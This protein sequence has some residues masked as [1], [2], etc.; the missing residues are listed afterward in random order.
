MNRENSATEVPG[1]SDLAWRLPITKGWM[2]SG[3]S[4]TNEGIIYVAHPEGGSILALEVGGESR[5]IPTGLTEH[6]ALQLLEDERTLA[7]ADPGHRM[8]FDKTSAEYIGNQGAGRAVLFDLSTSQV[9]V[10]LVQPGVLES[11]TSPWSPTSIAVDDSRHGTGEIWVADGYSMN[12]IHKY[13]KIG[14]HILS[15]DGSDSGTAFA[16]PHGIAI[17]RHEGI[18]SLYVADR[19]NRRIVVLDSNGDTK[20][21]FGADVLDSPSSIVQV[22]NLIY[23]TELFGSV[24]SFTLEGEYVRH[25]GPD[26]LRD[27]NEPLWPNNPSGSGLP[28]RPLLMPGR[29]NSPH[30]IAHF[31][32]QLF[33]TEWLIGGRLEAVDPSVF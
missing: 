6:H 12:L 2:H 18:F 8:Y 4:I 9:A 16:C 5:V 7:I 33:I 28:I 29:F 13:S 32:G 14:E 22:G 20:Q 23:V 21:V 1:W 3:I 31:R 19:A 17:V 10:E 25:L 15:L 24:V 27:H 30:G 11:S 26:R